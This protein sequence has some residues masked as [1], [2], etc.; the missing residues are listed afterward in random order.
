MGNSLLPQ[1]ESPG[2]QL[3]AGDLRLEDQ[4]AHVWSAM[5]DSEIPNSGLLS[6]DE[7][8]R[9]SRFHFRRDKNRFVGRRCFLR[10]CLGRYLNS[11]PD[12][13]E[14]AYDWRGKPR[15][16]GRFAKSELHFNTS[17]SA[18]MALLA[19]SAHHSVGIDLEKILPWND[20]E[21][22]VAQCFSPRETIAFRN[23]SGCE[24][25][26]SFFRLWTRKEAWLK[27]TGEGITES[28]RQIEVSFCPGERA[29]FLDI[30]GSSD[31]AKAWALHDLSPAQGFAAALAVRNRNLRVQCRRWPDEGV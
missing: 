15:L 19:V 26:E 6:P 14:F 24:A 9:A 18:G 13:I 7:S 22:L 21:Q 30:K 4:D 17:H 23:L 2:R 28:L 25:T 16:S 27:A 1:P 3:S 12:S 29:C 31:E 11:Q 5:V 8:Q 20:L 10:R